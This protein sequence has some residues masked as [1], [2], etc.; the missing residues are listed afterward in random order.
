MNA[1][2]FVLSNFNFRT[3]NALRKHAEQSHW[4]K[5]KETDDKETDNLIEETLVLHKKIQFVCKAICKSTPG[6]AMEN[7]NIF[8]RTGFQMNYF[9][10]NT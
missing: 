7:D 8:T 1:Y 2:S 4:E 10:Q 9:T 3:S 5:L 6:S